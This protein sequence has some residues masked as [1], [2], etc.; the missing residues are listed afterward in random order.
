MGA[1]TASAFRARGLCLL[2]AAWMLGSC[3]SPPAPG[4]GLSVQS[5]QAATG[6]VETTDPWTLGATVANLGD[7]PVAASTLSYYLSMDDF[8][9]AG[10]VLIGGTT[11]S[12]PALEAGESY[13][14]VYSLSF[15]I[16]QVWSKPGAQ[17]VLV[18][19]VQSDGTS[20]LFSTHVAVLYKEIVI[21]TFNPTGPGSGFEL[22]AMDLFDASGDTTAED[23]WTP[24]PAAALASDGIDGMGSNP[25]SNQTYFPYLQYKPAGG[26]A[27]GS[28]FYVRIRGYYHDSRSTGP[29]ALRILAASSADHAG[30]YFSAENT[31]D[32]PAEPDDQQNGVPTAPVHLALNQCTNRY[33]DGAGGDIDW[34]KVTLP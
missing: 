15:S 34:V 22:I 32:N 25:D 7:E 14:D 21:D 9:D 8:L 31:K 16:S 17:H 1:P 23:P 13:T 12:I 20:G 30:W 26:L 33:L 10:D 24:P 19:V 11:R 6:V 28:V 4:S 27:P 18:L 29:Y 2:I 5:I 3:G